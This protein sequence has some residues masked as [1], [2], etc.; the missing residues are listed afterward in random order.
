MFTSAAPTAEGLVAVALE[1]S[2][3][4]LLELPPTR[5]AFTLRSLSTC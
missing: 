2:V 4:M 1:D 5:F 3:Q